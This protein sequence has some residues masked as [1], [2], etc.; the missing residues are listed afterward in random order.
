MR[1]GIA[2]AAGFGTAV[3]LAAA[4]RAAR[5]D[6]VLFGLFAHDVS[7]GLSGRSHENDTYDVQ[8]DY[9]T[10][11]FDNLWFVLKPIL[12][13]KAQVSLQDRTDFFTVGA[14]TRKHF[15]K[16]RFYIGIGLGLT[17]QDG[18]RHYPSLTQPGLTVDEIAERQDVRS[19][20]KALGSDLLFNPNLIFGLT[21]DRRW[22]V[23]LAYDHYSNAGIF[24]D[25]NPGLDNFGVR[26]VYKF[27]PR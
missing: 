8:F 17:L 18:Y 10:R 6:E 5:A 13:G 19:T 26:A 1:R 3:S 4:P 12:Y 9:R 16:G 11:R 24:S 20:R 23:E 21:L 22:A 7:S 14:L 27:G 15:F 2:I 25:R